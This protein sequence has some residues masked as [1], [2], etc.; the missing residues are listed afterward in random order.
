[1]H[2]SKIAGIGMYVPQHV[3]TNNDLLKER[4]YADR[5]D[6]TTTVEEPVIFPGS[7]FKYTRESCRKVFND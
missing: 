5:T 4:R 6:E 1:M 2:R 3:V 7:S